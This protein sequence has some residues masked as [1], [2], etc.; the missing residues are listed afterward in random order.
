MKLFLC[1]NKIATAFYFNVSTLPNIAKFDVENDVVSTLSN[2][3]HMNVEIHNV[4]SRLFDI[5]NPN[6][7]INN[8]VSTLICRC[9]TSRR[10]MNQK[11]TLGMYCQTLLISAKQKNVQKAMK[12]KERNIIDL[13]FV[14]C[15][16][17]H[18]YIMLLTQFVGY[19]FGSL[20]PVTY[21]D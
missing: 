13:A 17:I 18:S 3:V 19:S 2:V 11:T 16:C 4:D 6:I 8:V 21:N 14:Q 20:M 9:P 7:D 12:V 10:H 15:S 1:F 5:V